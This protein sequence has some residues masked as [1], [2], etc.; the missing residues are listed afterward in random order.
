MAFSNPTAAKK[1]GFSIP[2]GPQA[3]PSNTACERTVLS[4]IANNVDSI[5]LQN[6]T[7][8]MF[9]DARNKMIFHAIDTLAK[10]LPGGE[11]EVTSG[12]I[13]N[14]CL[15]K[16]LLTEAGGQNYIEECVDKKHSETYTKKA[17]S[18]IK[19]CAM[20]RRVIN[21]CERLKAMVHGKPTDEIMALYNDMSTSVMKG[22]GISPPKTA[23]TVIAQIL[24][25]YEQ[26]QTNKE[27]NGLYTGIAPIDN[28]LQGIKPCYFVLG[29]LSSTGKT[30]LAVAVFYNLILQ[31]KKVIFFSQEM[32][33]AELIKRI[34]T[35][36]SGIGVGSTSSGVMTPSDCAK[37]RKHLMDI[38][39][40]I[41]DN[42]EIYDSSTMTIA[43]VQAKSMAFQ[44]RHGKI[45]AI[46][47]DYLQA[48]DIDGYTAANE[49]AKVQEISKKLKGLGKDM[50][51][52]M[53]ALSQITPSGDM[54]A[55]PTPFMLRGSRQ[56]MQ[57]ADIILLMSR[58][59]HRKD[60]QD[61]CDI[62][63]ANFA[64]GRSVGEAAVD[65]KFNPK[66]MSFS[67]INEADYS[68]QDMFDSSE[69]VTDN[70]ME[71]VKQ[72]TVT[73]TKRRMVKEA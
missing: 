43:D 71:A 48:L 7:E 8:E 12:Q 5:Y 62:L 47:V 73:E 57:D 52:L 24:E 56:I 54:S 27:T 22:V 53:F 44:R 41:D 50:G 46:L 38:Q 64:K 68:G 28:F 4:C 29:A 42:A 40:S 70:N 18:D 35:I 11:T 9:F 15:N 3:A 65:M 63:L 2:A 66:L 69:L 31:G 13:V 21:E 32:T 60:R 49:A 37:A 16:Q 19:D 36:A 30:A 61:N 59:V 20:Q 45:D 26:F 72:P 39:Q 10:R 55:E 67:G 14:L 17:I 51:C 34:L 23:K 58:K 1:A 33:A 25:E 6:I